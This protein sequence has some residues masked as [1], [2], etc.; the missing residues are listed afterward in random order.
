MFKQSSLVRDA[1]RNILI[2]FLCFAGPFLYAGYTLIAQV[3][4]QQA[5][6]SMDERAALVLQLLE[7]DLQNKIQSLQH[8]T[9]ILKAKD[10]SQTSRED[11][12]SISKQFNGVVWSG[13][14]GLDGKVQFSTQG[15]LEGV[16]VNARPWFK[17]GLNAPSILDR[18]DALLLASKLPPRSDP[19]KFIDMAVP[20]FSRENELKGVLAIHL[21]WTWY[22]NQ[23]S[24]LLGSQP[25]SSVI[26]SVVTGK[27]GELRVA[28]LG[29]GQTAADLAQMLL[30]IKAR[31]A[32][33]NS[34]PGAQQG[35]YLISTIQPPP[36]SKVGSLGW[37]VHLLQPAQVVASQSISA[38]SL[39]M[40]A[41]LVG[42]LSIS[43]LM[44]Y[45]A[46]RLS[47]RIARHLDVIEHRSIEEME[48]SEATLPKEAAPLMQRTREL[49]TRARTKAQL[50]KQ[51]LAIAET[52]FT[53]IN[54]LIQQAPVAIAMFD[55][56]MKYL[57]CSE[58]WK[59]IYITP[60]QDPI[61]QSHYQVV[62]NIPD[63]W[64]FYHQRGLQGEAIQRSNECW[65]DGDGKVFWLNWSIEPWLD[66]SKNVGGIIIATQDVTESHVAQIAL[67]ASEE[68]FQ[69]A[70]EGSSDGLWDWTVTDGTVY[71]SPGWKKMLGY[72][73]DELANH[74]EVWRSLLHP[75]DVEASEAYL[76]QVI[77]DRTADSLAFSFRLAH[78]NGAWV[79][80]LSRGKILRDKDG[81]ATRVVGTHFDRTE[82]EKLQS[83]LQEAWVHAQAEAKSN[84]AKSKFLATVSH[85]IRN[86][87]N[88]VTGFA[89]LIVEE[90]TEPNVRRYAQMLNQTTDSLRLILNDI[91]DF[92]KIDAGKLEIVESDFNLSDLIDTLGES[93]RLQCAEK[94]IQ[95]EVIKNW[96]SGSFFKGDVGRIRQ[97]VQNLLSNAVKFTSAGVVRLEVS[98]RRIDKRLEE[99]TLEVSDTGRGIPSEK[100]DML[101][102]PFSQLHSDS[103]SKFGG[104]GLGLTI[105]KSLAEAMGGQVSC[106]SAEGV[107]SRFKVVLPLHPGLAPTLKA[108]L[109]DAPPTGK[110][111]LIADDLP[112]NLHILSAFLSKRGHA[113]TTVEN[114]QMA[115][116]KLQSEAFDFVLLDFDMPE[117]NG[118]DVVRMIRLAKGPNQA[119]TF[120][121][122]TGH[123]MRET[124][125]AAQEAG[126]D[127]FIPKPVDF[128]Q[129]LVAVNQ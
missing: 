32:A 50:L 4:K 22:Q 125:E 28:Q 24:D 27:D 103:F 42:M 36:K 8:A 26:S 67:A 100:L 107:G 6:T 10:F 20:V 72:R 105:V 129:L 91:L 18:H 48:K 47:V 70:M 54:S 83:E 95:F 63:Q 58:L 118:P 80:V 11:V 109:K 49:F 15:I 127:F 128:D 120:A 108:E 86:P 82:I 55:R 85:E 112:S 52:S 99:V 84:E 74:Y 9:K 76:N 64:R 21:D 75:D 39:A 51:Q 121:C 34:L 60:G 37:T 93:A 94:S 87:L 89:R 104:T 5:L 17:A 56:D 43:L 116:E 7:N 88:A 69:L 96:D 101:F 73:V 126:F 117:I 110:R 113:V 30:E 53:E 71:L 41:L 114:G 61:A 12:E 46:R 65:T 66:K 106:V 44:I 122:V 111:V 79:K 97:I 16:D 90:T 124:M 14:A 119:S 19:Y 35:H 81:N 31:S 38:I 45:S 68:R 59:R 3:N 98:S 102:K 77:S 1:I 29:S 78:K 115:L 23:F 92:A 2:V 62:P 33:E 25:A 57:A 123:A 13:L 40:S